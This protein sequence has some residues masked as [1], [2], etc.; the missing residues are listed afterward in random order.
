MGASFNFPTLKIW[1]IDLLGTYYIH[2]NFQ[3]CSICRTA[4]LEIRI[5]I[6][7][8]LVLETISYIAAETNSNNFTLTL[9]KNMRVWNLES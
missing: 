1:E 6:F 8:A 2:A 7:F 4:E 5:P 9:P 3:I